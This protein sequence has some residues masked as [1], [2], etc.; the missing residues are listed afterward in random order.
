MQTSVPGLVEHPAQCLPVE[1][2]IG[3]FRMVQH[4]SLVLLLCQECWVCPDEL[5]PWKQ[6]LLWSMAAAKHRP[7]LIEGGCGL[8]WPALTR[9]AWS[10]AR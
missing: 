1:S 4:W 2:R 8:N 9:V 10:Y 5:F 3:H 6:S 7:D